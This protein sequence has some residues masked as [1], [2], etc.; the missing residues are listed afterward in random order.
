MLIFEL[1]MLAV[2]PKGDTGDTPSSVEARFFGFTWIQL[3]AVVVLGLG[4]FYLLMWLLKGAGGQARQGATLELEDAI[5]SLN[6]RV[7]M[8]ISIG[9]KAAGRVEFELFAKVAPRT[10]E[11][12]RALSTGEMG[13]GRTG[14]PLH[15]KR[16][17]FHRIIPGFMCQGGD[18]TLGNGRGGESIYG[19][20]FK[21]EWQHG[22]IPHS[23][24]GLLSMANRG[25]DTQSSQFFITLAATPWLDHLHVVFGRVV[26]GMDVVTAMEAVGTKSGKPSKAVA[27]TDC[28]EVEDEE[29]PSQL[30]LEH[31]EHASTEE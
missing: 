25:R 17:R 13:L 12:F 5:D 6:P 9:G 21:D 18:F 20:T 1:E 7:F 31:E 26:Q 3:T 27:V 23:G 30:D 29:E 15:Y 16:S 14:K 24:A 11:N 10:V 8:D 4:I 28:G 22:V 19:R 2:D